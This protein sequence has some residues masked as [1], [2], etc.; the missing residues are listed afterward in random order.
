MVELTACT[1]KYAV[2]NEVKFALIGSLIVFHCYKFG[3]I[4]EAFVALRITF[5]LH[6]TLIAP[7]R[8]IKA[9][10]TIA[11]D[12]LV[13]STFRIDIGLDIKDAATQI[14]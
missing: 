13:A 8:A 4:V 1:G 2:P 12:D 9:I 3:E 14:F 10:I 6:M 7:T 11:V 5:I